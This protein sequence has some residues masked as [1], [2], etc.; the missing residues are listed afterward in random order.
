MHNILNTI[1]KPHN[2]N[3]NICLRMDNV[4]WIGIKKNLSQFGRKV[5]IEKI[6]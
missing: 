1:T 3:K 2:D 6:I 4:E 5:Y